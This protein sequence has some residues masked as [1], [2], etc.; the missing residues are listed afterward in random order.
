MDMEL[1]GDYRP[2]EDEPYMNSNQLAYFQG[3]LLSWREQ[4]VR[5]SNE[6]LEQL[7]EEE[8]READFLDQGAFDTI[9]AL[10]FRTRDRYRKLIKKIDDALTRIKEGTYGYC[11]ETGEEI[12]IKRL[13]ARPIATLTLEAQEWHEMMEGR[14]RKSGNR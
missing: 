5:E 1:Q 7:R 3:K 13:D 9:K 14:K 6:T 8:W 4:L 11:E 2:T 12:G 10:T